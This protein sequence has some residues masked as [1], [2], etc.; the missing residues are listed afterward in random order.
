MMVLEGIS[1]EAISYPAG[2]EKDSAI[3][4]CRS[5]DD[6]KNRGN[7]PIECVDELNEGEREELELLIDKALDQ[8]FFCLYG[9]NILSYSSYDVYTATVQKASSVY[10]SVN[11]LFAPNPLAHPSL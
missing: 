9:F 5:V 10:A 8:R 4:E 7:K 11:F 2:L 6:G 3:V 1:S